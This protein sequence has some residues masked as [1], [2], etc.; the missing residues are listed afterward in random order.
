MKNSS[1]T[2]KWEDKKQEPSKVFELM[3]DDARNYT[4]IETN[5]R[6]VRTEWIVIGNQKTRIRRCP[7]C[8]KI[9][10]YKSKRGYFRG[11]KQA[12]FCRSCRALQRRG[13][14]Y[15]P[16]DRTGAR[17]S[18]E[19][20]LKIGEAVKIRHKT[21]G[22]PMK[23]KT[24]TDAVKKFLSEKFSGKGNPLYGKKRSIE[25]RMKISETRKRNKIPGPKI[26]EEGLIT[27]RKKRIK[28][29]SVD[30]FNGNQVM[31]SYNKKSCLFFNDLEKEL[32]WDGFYATKQGG[33]Y[34]IKELGFFLD[35]YNPHKNIVI[36]W[37]EKRHFNVDGS[38]REKDILRQKQTEKHL[39][40][41]FLRIKEEEFNKDKI[42]K[43]IKNYD[44]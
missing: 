34:H 35:Y 6:S 22:H 37:D 20:K 25:T 33:E 5:Q 36:E 43:E 4:I 17:L 27:L 19:H 10:I 41:V 8:E 13:D 11:K 16:P 3:P 31:P 30:K 26:S 29:I 1:N 7:R 28:E 42:L 39:K 44:N 12:S 2:P 9:M 24:H 40:C 15:L 18:D 38:L 23:G 32:G 14:G 21:V